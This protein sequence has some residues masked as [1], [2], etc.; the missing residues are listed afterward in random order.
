M[1]IVTSYGEKRYVFF[2]WKVIVLQN[3]LKSCLLGL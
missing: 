2:D 1:T 3:K